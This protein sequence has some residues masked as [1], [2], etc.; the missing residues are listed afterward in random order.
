MASRH[1][2]QATDVRERASVQRS[3]DGSA[4]YKLQ[5]PKQFKS[6]FGG[7]KNLKKD[8]WLSIIR[9]VK[10]RELKGKSSA[11][12][13]DGR[14]LKPARVEREVAR[15]SGVGNARISGP[16]T[17]LLNHFSPSVTSALSPTFMCI[18]QASSSH[19]AN[20]ECLPA[21]SPGSCRVDIRTPSPF[22]PPADR[23]GKILLL[24]VMAGSHADKQKS[25]KSQLTR[26]T[27]SISTRATSVP[28]S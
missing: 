2:K 24:L 20:G 11:V 1:R 22:Q 28:A 23:Q 10:R 21:D 15:Y 8:E 16:E 14:R 27:C 12:F 7:H 19:R 26:R 25:C 18:Q 4:A 3:S 17:G 13:L 9:K 5:R 6:R